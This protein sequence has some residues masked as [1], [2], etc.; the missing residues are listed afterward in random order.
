MS[1]ETVPVLE[2]VFPGRPDLRELQEPVGVPGFQEPRENPETE[3]LQASVESQDLPARQ[4]LAVVLVVKE[5][6][7]PR[8]TPLW[9]W[10]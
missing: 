7:A 8:T 6:R 5:R 2:E 10:E 9:A 1:S 3:D 4:E